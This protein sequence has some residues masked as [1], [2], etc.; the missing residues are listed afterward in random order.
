MKGKVR[1]KYNERRNKK[2]SEKLKQWN[3]KKG[4]KPKVRYN[5]LNGQNKNKLHIKSH[6]Y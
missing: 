4:N 3:S 6:K 1:L 5:I 2:P